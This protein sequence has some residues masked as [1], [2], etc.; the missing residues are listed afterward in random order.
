[1]AGPSTRKRG[2][3]GEEMGAGKG[4]AQL[5]ATALT[6]NGSLYVSGALTPYDVENLCDQIVT[7]GRSQREDV[8]VEVD[9][10][11]LPADSPELRALARR[12]KRLRQHGVS[13]RLHA[14]RPR[15][16]L[17]LSSRVDTP[18]STR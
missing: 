9:L 12:V 6:V 14:A 11:G 4:V 17:R 15:K 18:R 1:M 5:S 3:G 13:V 2:V 7:F 8:H 10:G 16:R